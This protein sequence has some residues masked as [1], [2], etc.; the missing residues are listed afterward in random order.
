[1]PCRPDSL[2]DPLSMEQWTNLSRELADVLAQPGNQCD[3]F[4]Y[5]FA[6]AIRCLIVLIDNAF[7]L[8]RA[9]AHRPRLRT[10]FFFLEMRGLRATSSVE[11]QRRSTENWSRAAEKMGLKPNKRSDGP[12]S[13]PTSRRCTMETAS[14]HLQTTCGP[15]A[16]DLWAL[17]RPLFHIETAT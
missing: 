15:S 11:P 2:E 5:K 3:T 8:A 12:R 6:S 4:Y 13:H 9:P 7:V 10:S 1:M 16:D 14:R 17:R